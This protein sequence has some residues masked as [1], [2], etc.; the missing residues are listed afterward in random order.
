MKSILPKFQD[1][2]VGGRHYRFA[3][4]FPRPERPVPRVSWSDCAPLR[5]PKMVLA[6]KPFGVVTV[7]AV[8]QRRAGAD[9]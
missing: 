5:E 4:L 2:A 7:G 3:L 9:H 6:D 1:P 8:P